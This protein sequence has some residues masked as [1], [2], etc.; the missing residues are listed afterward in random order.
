MAKPTATE[1]L[2]GV[3]LGGWLV[4]ERWITPSLFA[5]LTAKDEYGLC[6][7]LG[8]EAADI[9]DIHRRN[10][11]T[12]DDF[13]W[14]AQHGITAIR[15]PVG[16]WLFEPE[17]PFVSGADYVDRAFEWAH[18]FKLQV[19][20]DLHGAPG[21]QNGRAHSG[22]IGAVGW[23]APP[24]L[25]RTI[26]ILEQLAKRYGA[27]PNLW[28]IELCNEPDWRIG[29]RH[30]KHF[31]ETAYGAIRRHCGTSV[32][33]I[34]PDAYH[35]RR[36]RRV[37]QGATF[38]NRVLDVHLYQVFGRKDKR[39]DGAGHIAQALHWRRLL[40]K[41]GQRWP[42]IVGEWSA[43][44][45]GRTFHGLSAAEIEAIRRGYV[46]AQLL[47]FAG[48]RGWFYWSYRMEG[49]PAWSYRDAVENGWFPTEYISSP[50]R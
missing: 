22:R 35:P 13:R 33:V 11:I 4:L 32:A 16:Y 10:F 31:Y 37:M 28:G 44:L 14:L 2:R 43:A 21:N 6:Q 46:A 12:R 42:V 24:H 23:P 49:N 27:H 20:L 47:A 40:D 5:G 18:E 19:V 48:T 15:L 38:Q 30:L 26:A 50:K 25:Q 41:V 1:P 34:V 36:W 39:R 45:D 17:P 29:K 8:A 9:L 3:N 7:E